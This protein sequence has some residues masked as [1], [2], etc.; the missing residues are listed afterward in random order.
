MS[1]STASPTNVPVGTWRVDTLHSSVGFAVRHNLIST[2]RGR[3]EEYDAS[4]IIDAT[5]RA[6]LTGTVNAGSIAVKD[7]TL[8]THLT[9][10]DFFDTERY[11]EL[12]F[13]STDIRRDGEKLRVNGELTIKG[14]SRQATV[15]GTITDVVEDPFGGTRIAFE[16]ETTIDRREYGLDWNM[17]MPRGG[18]YLSNDVTLTVTLEFTKADE[19]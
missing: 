14:R 1:I 3:F 15:R 9:A 4:L 8:A 2:F 11:P 19:R 5:G 12:R 17:P 7:G 16:L 13:H 6:T 18:L 10:P